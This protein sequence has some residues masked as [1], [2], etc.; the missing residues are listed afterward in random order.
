MQLNVTLQHRHRGDLSI[1]L[2]SPSGTRSQLLT[3]RR[4]DHSAR[5]IK[6][7]KKIIIIILL[8]TLDSILALM[9]VGPSNAWNKQFKLNLT[10]L[11]IQTGR[12]QISWL[13]TSVAE[14][15]NSGLPWA[16][17]ASGEGGTWARDLQIA[18]P[19]FQPLGHAA[20]YISWIL[21]RPIFWRIILVR[22]P[23]F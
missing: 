14:D 8:L 12:R 3:T 19:A 16:N 11:R 23:L 15:L 6:V 1:T 10:G 5:G 22:Q 4:N 17:P 18:S 9:L 2:I 13:F 21:F 7:A 20:F